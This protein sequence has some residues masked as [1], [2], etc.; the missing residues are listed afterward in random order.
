MT[1]ERSLDDLRDL[2]NEVRD[3]VGRCPG[4]LREMSERSPGDLWK[5]VGDVGEV[6][7]DLRD[8]IV[9]VPEVLE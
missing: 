7:R 5:A 8:L 9:D 1:S 4:G 6:I 2:V 3:I